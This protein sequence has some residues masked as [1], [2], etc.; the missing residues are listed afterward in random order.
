MPGSS[1]KAQ[2]YHSPFST[3]PQ[4]RE[5]YV[6]TPPSAGILSLSPRL[7]GSRDSSPWI[8]PNKRRPDGTYIL[9]LPRE[10]ATSLTSVMMS[11]SGNAAL[12][13][14]EKSIRIHAGTSQGEVL[15]YQ[16]SSTTT[17]TWTRRFV[18]SS[19][20]QVGAIAINENNLFALGV[21]GCVVWWDDMTQQDG[22]SVLPSPSPGGFAR[23]TALWLIPGTDILLAGCS[24]GIVVSW[25]ISNRVWLQ[26]YGKATGYQVAING[27]C[28]TT[29]GELPAEFLFVATR[30]QRPAQ[31]CF[32]SGE[33]IQEFGA[34]KAEVLVLSAHAGHLFAAGRDKQV[35]MYDIDS[36]DLIRTFAGEMGYISCLA[37]SGE[38][39]FF[40]CWDSTVK[41][42]NAG[43]DPAATPTLFEG[44]QQAIKCIA[45][46]GE[47]EQAGAEL[48]LYTA[49]TLANDQG[50]CVQYYK[51]PC[52]S[53]GIEPITI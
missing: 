51:V 17:T 33:L 28:T 24:T 52:L 7:G 53:N 18:H 16:I 50:L 19:L 48:G 41:L 27:L 36:G 37:V 5:G 38:M 12:S 47:H 32:E 25:S 46:A 35:S 9:Q 39:L 11:A 26:E 4:L 8:Q 29:K 3:P 40:G 20:G 22:G 45:L 13:A 15:E 6:P 31:W 1:H 2:R 44:Q 23:V 43:D 49:A 30:R 21:G 10:P 42:C 34:P 14:G